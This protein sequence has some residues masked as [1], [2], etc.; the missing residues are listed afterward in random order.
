MIP[1]P[2]LL[3]LAANRAPVRLDD[4]R[5]VRVV[6]VTRSR[7]RANVQLPSGRFMG[8]NPN[9]FMEVVTEVTAS[10]ETRCPKWETP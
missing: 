8:V 5:I 9:R 1:A 10:A 2:V 7:T 4:G 3:A 6:S